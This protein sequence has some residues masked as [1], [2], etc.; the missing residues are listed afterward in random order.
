MTELQTVV[1]LSLW[2]AMAGLASLVLVLYKQVD[3]L[4]G[5]GGGGGSQ[6]LEAGTEAPEIRIVSTSG[7]DTP[8]EA[9]EG[10]DIYLVV[11]L[12]QSCSSCIQL[13]RSVKLSPHLLGKVIGLLIGETTGEFA[14]KRVAPMT[15]FSLT[16]PG[17]VVRTYAVSQ[18]PMTYAISNGVI[19]GGRHSPTVRDLEDILREAEDAVAKAD[20]VSPPALTGR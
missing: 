5:A 2:L 20:L 18:T 14:M 4:Y 6:P 15:L 12:M 7:Q 8:L 19:L 16:D 13:V 9:P 17:Q 10:Q 1:V 11:F 3:R